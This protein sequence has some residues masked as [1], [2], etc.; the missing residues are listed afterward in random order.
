MESSDDS[1]GAEPAGRRGVSTAVHG[2]KLYQIGGYPSS[3]P[4]GI[5]VYDFDRS[6]WKVTNCA[7]HQSLRTT[8]SCSVVLKDAMYM[9]G[10]WCNGLR[11][12][13]LVKLDLN[14]LV[15]STLDMNNPEVGPMCKDKAGMVDYG[16]DML[17]IFGGYGWPP[18]WPLNLLEQYKFQKGASY[19]WDT[20]QGMAIGWTNELHLY[21]LPTGEQ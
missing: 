9:Y 12:A 17:C 20:D 1:T 15:W 11:S 2:G 18:N 6:C 16:E 3:T 13:C 21:H 14:D 8:G 5:D 10:G 7:S 19:H 4:T